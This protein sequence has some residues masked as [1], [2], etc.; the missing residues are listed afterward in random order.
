MK[1]F[2]FAAF[3]IVNC[4][5]TAE[6]QTTLTLANNTSK[7]IYAA[8]A[9]YDEDD[10]WTT[11][12]WYRVG[13]YDELELNLYDYAGTVYI[14]GHNEGGNWGKDVHLCTGGSNGFRVMN[15]DKI[16]CEYSR[17]F[18]KTT[19]SKDEDKVWRFNP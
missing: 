18:T 13:P 9:I 7:S 1:Y 6:A 2:L 14:H 11:Q 8:Y 16:R 10:G 5:N 12:G 3:I 15:A 17:K 19:I 4:L